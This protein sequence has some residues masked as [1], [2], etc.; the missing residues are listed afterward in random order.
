MQAELVRSGRLRTKHLGHASDRDALV[1][2]V[3]AETCRFEH[4]SKLAGYPQIPGTWT[5]YQCITDERGPK[6]PLTGLVG[7]RAG[8]PA[9]DAGDPVT[10]TAVRLLPCA[11]DVLEA[12]DLALPGIRG[13]DDRLLRRTLTPLTDPL[14]AV[15]LS[16][17]ATAHLT[18]RA[19]APRV[20]QPGGVDTTSS[21]SRT[22][23]CLQP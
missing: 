11:D 17:A 14:G 5:D 12:R 13:L 3:F 18:E 20:T 1:E 7:D 21:Q 4:G 19:A 9:E 16:R 22:G 8:E 2:E 10:V 15:L 23:V 6:V